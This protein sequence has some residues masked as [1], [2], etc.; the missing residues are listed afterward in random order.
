MMNIHEIGKENN[1]IILLIPVL[2][3]LKKIVN[4]WKISFMMLCRAI[5]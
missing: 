5:I 2:T 4:S 3:K 1:E